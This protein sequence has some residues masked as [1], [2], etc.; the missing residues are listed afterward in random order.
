MVSNEPSC[1]D[2]FNNG[3]SIGS[4]M[5]YAD[6]RI[7]ALEA[8]LK[9]AQEE[10]GAEKDLHQRHE[11]DLMNERDEWYE[12]DKAAQERIEE[13]LSVNAEFTLRVRDAE[14]EA[15]QAKE[16]R[17]ETTRN[18]THDLDETLTD[19]DALSQ[20]AQEVATVLRYKSCE[21]YKHMG[22]TYCQHGY[23]PDKCLVRA[24]L[25][26]YHAFKQDKAPASG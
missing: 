20:V 13:L 23:H 9:A 6:K 14:E 4:V 3:D 15:R 8:E 12:R 17:D 19:Y 11:T 10:L 1:I 2:R 5:Q 26:R 21:P 25:A 24:A 7:A 16:E 22:L 18:L